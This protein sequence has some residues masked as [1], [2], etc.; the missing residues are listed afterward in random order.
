MSLFKSELFWRF[1]FVGH[2]VNVPRVRA[3]NLTYCAL[4][5]LRISSSLSE[6]FKFRAWLLRLMENWAALSCSKEQCS[7]SL[8]RHPS[9]SPN[10]H[11]YR[12]LINALNYSETGNLKASDF[13][14]LFFC[15]ARINL[16]KHKSVTLSDT[17]GGHVFLR[18]GT[19][20][21]DSSQDL[22]LFLMI[23]LYDF[24]KWPLK[25]QCILQ[26]MNLCWNWSQCVVF[27]GEIT[28]LKH[29]QH[30]SLKSCHYSHIALKTFI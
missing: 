20:G 29:C 24:Q 22:C 14:A 28:V 4:T 16:A 8:S 3:L 7:R 9:I 13:F 12:R 25:S 26:W 17:W 21:A 18:M 6:S 1:C 10:V 2:D 30:C 23:E 5:V 27:H 11:R 15:W 19:P